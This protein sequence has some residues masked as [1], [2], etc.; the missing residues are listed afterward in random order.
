MNP[1]P[2]PEAERFTPQEREKEN[3]LQTLLA[4]LLLARQAKNDLLVNQLVQ[5]IDELRRDPDIQA[6]TARQT[7]RIKNEKE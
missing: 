5:E 6:G 1:Q 2:R 7:E 3:R 4:Q